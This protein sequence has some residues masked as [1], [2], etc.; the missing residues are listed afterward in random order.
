MG[1]LDAP[2]GFTPLPPSK[3]NAFLAAVVTL[4]GR[5]DGRTAVLG[6]R[7]EERHSNPLGTC[8][9]GMLLTFADNYLPTII[10]LQEGS[11]DG[12]TPTV[13]MTADFLAPARQGQWIEG[14]GR[15]LRRTGRLLFTEGLVS[16]EGEPVL[17]V[18]AI[19]KRG[20]T[21]DRAQRLAEL[22]KLLG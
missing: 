10:R 19:F 6:F 12:F 3:G 14:R 20:K 7:V 16:A 17:R 15:L 1:D 22:K 18:S 2:E 4:W 8:N 5:F 13:S 9:G 21:G 11:E